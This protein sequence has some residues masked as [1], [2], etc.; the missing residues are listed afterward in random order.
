MFEEDLVQRMDRLVHGLLGNEEQS[1]AVR[2]VTQFEPLLWRRDQVQQLGR[3]ALGRLNVD[4]QRTDVGTH[5]NCCDRDSSI[6]SQRADDASRP[7]RCPRNALRQGAGG[8][9]ELS[10]ELASDDASGAA[11]PLDFDDA[12]GKRLHLL[13]Q[14]SMLITW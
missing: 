7:H 5:S 9:P 2:V 11:G 10:Q 3:Q 1:S 4:A 6:M 12:G 8:V 13:L 14:E